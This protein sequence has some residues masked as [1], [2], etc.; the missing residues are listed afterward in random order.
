MMS[1]ATN[2]VT[3][4]TTTGCGPRR[5]GFSLAELL[6][7]IS[8][9]ALLIAIALPSFNRAR[10]QAKAVASAAI[11]NSIESGL[12]LFR[13]ESSLGTRYP[14]SQSD[15]PS[16]QIAD[17]YSSQDNL[18]LRPTGAAL[19]VLAL[20]GPDN[21]GTVGFAGSGG[22]RWASTVAGPGSGEKYDPATNT[23]R[24]GPYAEGKLLES[25]LP[26]E[27]V[28][29]AG[30]R[31]GIAQRGQLKSTAMSAEEQR[32][33]VFVDE[34]DRPILYYRARRA[35]K[36]MITKPGGAVGVYDHRDN[37]LFTGGKEPGT[38]TNVA[39]SVF[40]KNGVHRINTTRYDGDSN[41]G[42]DPGTG[43]SSPLPFDAY[44]IDPKSTVAAKPVNPTTFLLISAGPD[45]I[46]GTVDDVKN[47]GK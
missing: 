34:F 30:N 46:Y 36:N 17:P 40:V 4:G 2:R 19:L 16:G 10:Q 47:W 3:A 6:V 28:D 29:F 21:Q 24:Y 41:F 13:G 43:A 1:A 22:G 27:G 11:L 9:I 12:E 20:A 33:R 37:S 23:P 25:I 44:I 5:A 45:G 32:L 35:A 26:V 8:I 38:N 18:V 39:G 14:P 15:D 7:V 31:I 42:I